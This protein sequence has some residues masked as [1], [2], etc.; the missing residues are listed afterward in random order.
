MT[1]KVIQFKMWLMWKN[2]Q[3]RKTTAKKAENSSLLRWHSD[4][5]VAITMILYYYCSKSNWL[6]HLILMS[7]WVTEHKFVDSTNHHCNI[8]PVQFSVFG[9]HL[10]VMSKWC[11]CVCVCGVRSFFIFCCCCCCCCIEH[12]TRVLRDMIFDQIH[13]SGDWP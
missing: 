7:E 3:P 9:I 1:R 10:F 4:D 2:P 8:I 13:Y 12:K 5:A 11:V 6:W